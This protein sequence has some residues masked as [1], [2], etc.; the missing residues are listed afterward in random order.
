M[1]FL[2]GYSGFVGGNLAAQHRFDGLFRSGNITEAYG[3]KPELLVYSGVRAEMFLANQDPLADLKNIETA[4]AN[5]DAIAPKECVLISTIAV[6]PD[7]HNAD[8]DFEIDAS[9]LSAYGA[10]RLYLERWVE[11]NIPDSLIVRL[12]A[13]YGPGLK[14]NFLYDYINVIPAMLKKDKFI[15]LESDA[16]EL[17]EFYFLQ[18]NGFYKCSPLSADEKKYL[19]QLFDRLGFSAVSFTD[20]RSVYQFY[21]LKHLWRHIELARANGLRRLNITTPPIS[22]G[23]VYKYLSGRIFS[24]ELKATPYNYDL[25]SKHASLFGGADGYIMSREEELRDIAEFVNTEGGFCKWNS[26]PQI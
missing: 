1:D 23:E 24:N 6:Y 8:E 21:S 3:K 19:K 25:R 15:E 22:V 2:V 13:I 14:K 7:T 10:N 4:I 17:K 5:I 9:A 26:P 12:P 20:S 11:A 16:P 18:D